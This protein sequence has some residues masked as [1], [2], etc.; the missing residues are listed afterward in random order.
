VGRQITAILRLYPEP[1][2]YCRALLAYQKRALEGYNRRFLLLPFL[3]A[4][5]G[6]GSHEN[7]GHF[8]VKRPDEFWFNLGCEARPF[9][10]LFSILPS[11]IVFI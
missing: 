2:T 6:G 1:K 5:N 3:R 8:A 4:Y 11:L 10:S 9:A 7:H